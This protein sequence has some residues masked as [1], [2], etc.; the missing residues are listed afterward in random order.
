MTTATTTG[1]HEAAALPQP[2][3]ELS[4]AVIARLAGPFR[5]RAP[6]IEPEPDRVAGAIEDDDL[7]LALYLCYELHYTGFEGVDPRWEWDPG[8]IGFRLRLEEIFTAGL[9]AVV[10]ERTPDPATIGELLF[11]LAAADEGPSLSRHLELRGTDREFREFL[12]QRSA[13]QLKEADPHTW[14]IPRLSGAP[15]AAMVEIQADEYG[16]GRPERMHSALFAKTMRALGLDDRRG[17]YLDLIPGVTLAAVNLISMLGLNRRWRGALAG[18]LAMFEMTSSRPNRRYANGLRRLGHPPDATD[19][20]DEHVEA[21]AV[22]ENIAA[23][24]LAEGLARRDPELA[25]QIV[26][27]AE[28][29]QVLD[30]RGAARMLG[31][32]AAGGTSLRAPL[33]AR[34]SPES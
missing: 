7:Q 30:R 12:V 19:F 6:E 26:F 1:M 22:H 11:E 29:L 8:L 32:W 9:K 2:A 24:D 17:A 33:P 23:Y 21:D 20:F 27:G 3:G 28:G 16:G 13:Y 5:R 34:H 10:P 25:A 4:S 14:A 31:R 18:H 15:K